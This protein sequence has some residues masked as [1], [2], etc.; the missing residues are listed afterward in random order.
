DGAGVN[1]NNLGTAFKTLNITPTNDAPTLD[2]IPSPT[3]VFENSG[4]QVV[5]LSGITAGGGEAQT[6]TIAAVTSNTALLTLSP[7][8]Y[9]SPNSTAAFSFIPIGNTFGTAT[10]SVTVTD[11]GG[12]TNGGVNFITRT[13]NVTVLQVNQAPTLTAIANPNP[14]NE[15]SG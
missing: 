15:N 10:I 3:P 9:S 2:P 4:P 6:L 13:F 1:N 14:V 5:N 8:T 11:A 12:V 7:I